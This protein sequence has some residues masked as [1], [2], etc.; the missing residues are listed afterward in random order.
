MNQP[1]RCAAF[2]QTQWIKSEQIIVRNT[3]NIWF[4]CSCLMVIPKQSCFTSSRLVRRVA[5]GS[6]VLFHHKS[7][8]CS[9]VQSPRM[10]PSY[11]S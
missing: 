3:K 1:V 10:T 9:Q 11:H 4:E 2:A 8:K 7:M 5:E 6:C